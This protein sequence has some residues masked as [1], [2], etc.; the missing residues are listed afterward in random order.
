M[1]S[2]VPIFLVH[3]GRRH[4]PRGVWRADDPE[5][6]LPRYSTYATHEEMSLG[7]GRKRT[8]EEEEYELEE[9]HR[10]ANVERGAE[11][12]H[13]T[14]GSI[15]EFESRRLSVGRMDGVHTR[16]L[17]GRQAPESLPPYVP[18]PA[19]AY[20]R[21]GSEMSLRS[22]SSRQMSMGSEQVS[23]GT[24]VAPSNGRSSRNFL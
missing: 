1:T 2:R 4:C 24:L 20:I 3:H 7:I 10:E 6:G 19:P 13:G 8:A 16:A 21:K 9:L 5:E 22:M 18:V 12:G 14:A 15:E 17:M 11:M 23:R